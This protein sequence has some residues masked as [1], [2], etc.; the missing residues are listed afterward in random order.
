M[1]V[2]HGEPVVHRSVGGLATGLAAPHERSE[3]L[4]VGWPGDLGALDATSR[5][6]VLQRL[7]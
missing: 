4:W 6:R 3:G 2:E 5:A 7:T 1:R